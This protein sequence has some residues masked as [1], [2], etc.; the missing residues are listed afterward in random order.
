MT[1]KKM[2]IT[3]ASGLIGGLVV[4]GLR[5]KYEFSG[6]NRRR[7]EGIPCLQADI[8]D[9]EAILPAFK[10]IDT[11]LHLSAYTE[12]ANEWEGTLRVNIVGSYNVYEAAR[13]NGVKRVVLASTGDTMT[14]YEEDSPY[15][16]LAAGKYDEVPEKWTMVDYTWLFRPKS[17]YGASKVFCEALGRHYSD[18]YNMSVLC[19]RLGAV[20]DVDQ[21]IMRRHY[22]GWL[23]QG[24]CVQMVDKC[25]SAPDSL[26]FDIFDAISNNRYKWRDTSHATEVLGWVPQGS[27]DDYEIE[28]KGGWHQ[29][30]QPYMIPDRTD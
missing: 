3:G 24:D 2:L 23:S 27:A 17:L 16:Q 10:G 25:L 28:D 8:S 5:D 30:K 9:L 19:I 7:V 13:R 21:P 4:K 14:G 18:A 22:P 12:D 29:V 20:L 1:G 6:L 11:V 26:K 15:G